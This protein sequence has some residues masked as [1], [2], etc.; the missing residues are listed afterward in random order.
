MA[1]KQSSLINMV[2]TLFVIT[3]VA[4]VAL[5]FVYYFTKKP[6]DNV[7]KEKLAKALNDVLPEFDSITTKD[8]FQL[9]YNGKTEQVPVFKVSKGES[10]VGTAIEITTHK[11]FGGDV[12][13]LVGFDLEGK[14]YGYSVLEHKETAGLGSK[15]GDWFND[16]ARENSYVKGRNL[17]EEKYKDGIKVSKDDKTNGIDAITAATISSRAF[18]DALN[19]AYK[20]YCMTKQNADNTVN[21]AADTASANETP[22]DVAENTKATETAETENAESEAIEAEST[23]NVEPKANEGGQDNE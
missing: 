19:N 2:L 7:K 13:I 8:T 20:I 4:A 11:G 22:A 17:A 12:K 18:C 6:I 14:I 10:Q 9:E 5:G 21:N 23:E 3:T 1:K 16:P 15:M